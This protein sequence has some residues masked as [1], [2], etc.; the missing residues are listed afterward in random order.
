MAAL[1]EVLAEGSCGARRSR[2]SAAALT[3]EPLEAYVTVPPGDPGREGRGSVLAAPWEG[4][5][6]GAFLDQRPNRLLAGRLMPEGGRALD[7]FSYHGSFAIH[8]ARRAGSVLALDVSQEALDRGAGNAALNGLRNIDW[9]EA[10]VFERC[11]P[12]ESASDRRHRPD[13]CVRQVTRDR[14]RCSRGDRSS[15]AAMRLLAQGGTL[16]TGPLLH[17]KLPIP[18]HAREAAGTGAPYRCAGA[19]HG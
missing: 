11:P 12:R 7:C 8:L 19:G 10:D 5:K 2:P 6:T 14:S 9:R 18:R 17:V 15:S 3:S 16:L 4:Q 1:L 13:P